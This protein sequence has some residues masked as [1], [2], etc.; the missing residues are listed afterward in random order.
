MDK[1]PFFAGVQQELYFLPLALK[2]LAA[3]EAGELSPQR[4]LADRIDA[5]GLGVGHL[6]GL[7]LYGTAETDGDGRPLAPGRRMMLPK[8]A[9]DCLDQ[10]R[11]LELIDDG[12]RVT[13]KGRECIGDR[14]VLRE[15]LSGNYRIAGE[16][17]QR[18]PVA[19]RFRRVCGWIRDAGE[20]NADDLQSV[21]YRPALCLAEFML[22]HF[23]LQ[24]ADAKTFGSLSAA[25]FAYEI[26]N[27]RQKALKGLDAGEGGI[28]YAALVMADAAVDRLEKDWPEAEDKIAAAKSTALMLC[29]ARV[30]RPVGLPGGLQWLRPVREWRPGGKRRKRKTQKEGGR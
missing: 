26:V 25:Q 1:A 3:A 24:Q 8:L 14:R 13:P 18:R 11:Q 12:D 9:D 23:W 21:R 19:R 17:G 22:L 28:E 7:G 27:D 15:T 29:N 20:E 6:E 4:V 5:E 30:I 16:D 2:A 10:L